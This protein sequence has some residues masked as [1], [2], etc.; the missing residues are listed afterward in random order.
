MRKSQRAQLPV[1]HTFADFGGSSGFTGL[2]CR[3]LGLRGTASP[4]LAHF[5]SLISFGKGGARDAS[6]YPAPENSEPT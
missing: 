4:L 2:G 6:F 3:G 1:Q 5:V